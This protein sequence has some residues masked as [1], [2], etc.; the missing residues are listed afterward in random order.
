MNLLNISK[1]K[2]RASDN[3]LR[4]AFSP[5]RIKNVS[6]LSEQSISISDK[7]WNVNTMSSSQLSNLQRQ[8]MCELEGDCCESEILN[9]L[10]HL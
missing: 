6:Q 7:V 8:T 2:F 10:S 3:D 4:T 1:L 9:K 5:L